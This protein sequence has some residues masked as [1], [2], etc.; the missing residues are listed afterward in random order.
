MNFT[1]IV[2]PHTFNSSHGHFLQ[3]VPR[4]VFAPSNNTEIVGS[5]PIRD[6]DVSVC[7]FCICVVLCISRDLAMG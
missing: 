6:M 2:F 7:L 3:A 4:T 5:N 1:L